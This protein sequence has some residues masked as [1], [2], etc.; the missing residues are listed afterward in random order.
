MI[1]DLKIHY[2]MHKSNSI[3]IKAVELSSYLT[4][5]ERQA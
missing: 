5:G 2:L 1:C 4:S 3:S